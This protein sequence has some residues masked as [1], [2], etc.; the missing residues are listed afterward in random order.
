MEAATRPCSD[1][2]GRE[3]RQV[4]HLTVIPGNDDIKP[5]TQQVGKPPDVLLD[6]KLSQRRSKFKIPIATGP[7]GAGWGSSKDQV[8]TEQLKYCSSRVESSLKNADE[9]NEEELGR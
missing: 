9:Y 5:A 1:R 4:S 6:A 2:V 8:G 7:P 3:D